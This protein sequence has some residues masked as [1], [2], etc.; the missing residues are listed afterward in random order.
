MPTVKQRAPLFVREMPSLAL[1]IVDLIRIDPSVRGLMLRGRIDLRAVPI[2]IGRDEAAIEI[3]GDL[4]AC[5]SL[6]DV[7][8]EHDRRAGD[9]PT[10]TYLRRGR[11]WAKLPSSAVL[12]LVRGETTILNPEVFPSEVCL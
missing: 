6:A 1:N 11:T 3:R 12:T 5:A 9:P 8:R 4:L 7:V 10:R 2:R